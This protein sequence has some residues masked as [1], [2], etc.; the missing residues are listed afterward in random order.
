MNLLGNF[1]A[2]PPESV[3]SQC[4]SDKQTEVQCVVRSHIHRNKGKYQTI[5][6][7]CSAAYYIVR[8]F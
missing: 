2:T 6:N 7:M 4:H 8:D 5:E 3:H 1:T